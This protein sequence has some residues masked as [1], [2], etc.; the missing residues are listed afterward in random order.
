[1]ETRRPSPHA[2]RPVIVAIGV[3]VGAFVGALLAASVGVD[4]PAPAEPAGV[5]HPRWAEPPLVPPAVAPGPTHLH[6][7][8]L[9][10]IRSEHGV[11]AGI[12]AF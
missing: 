12:M 5:F 6:E 11:H 10:S 4:G 7:P 2:L 1:M 9:H 3:M 8:E